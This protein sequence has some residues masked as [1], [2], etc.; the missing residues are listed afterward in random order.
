MRKGI[1]ENAQSGATNF[2]GRKYVCIGGNERKNGMENFQDFL[3]NKNGL[4]F[5]I[6]R[7][8]LKW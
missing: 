6:K 4:N 5:Q 1:K 2:R 8:N 7:R 3:S